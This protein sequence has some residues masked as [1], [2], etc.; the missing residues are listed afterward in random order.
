MRRIVFWIVAVLAAW[1]PPFGDARGQDVLRIAAIVN[2]EV[3]TIRDLALRID[4]V[5]ASTRFEDTPDNRSRLRNR[6]LRQLIDER[7]QLA[8]A[9]R[10]GISVAPADIDRRLVGLARENNMSREQFEDV[11]K[12]N[13][14]DIDALVQ[15]I[16]ADIAWGRVAQLRL[17]PLA[18][19]SDEE[20]DDGLAKFESARGQPEALVAE[21]LLP[22]DVR[23]HEDEALRAA[24]R[25]VDQIKA[26]AN[27]AAVARQFSGGAT[28]S[29]GGDIGWL[30]PGQ[31]SPELDNVVQALEVGQI[32]EPIRSVGGFT[33]LTVKERRQALAADPMSTTVTLS[34][35]VAT[36][37]RGAPPSAVEEARQKAMALA[38]VAVG[39]E[40]LDRRAAAA[41]APASGRLGN[42]SLRDLPADVRNMMATLPL[43]RASQPLQSDI[44]FRVLMVCE[45]TAPPEAKPPSRA[46]IQA[47]LESR[48]VALLAQRYLRNLRRDAF[49]EIR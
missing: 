18:K 21:I 13:G 19:V 2:E 20:V 43:G 12:R 41:K 36:I 30:L 32:S 37:D 46:D 38:S 49:V 44:G 9:K 40:D 3:I 7:L 47:G 23:D 39:C 24:Q 26:G 35:F 27:F 5:I 28:A 48:R 42:F 14:M 25:L 31:L 45:R 4:L 8:E 33:I 15:Q 16:T 29:S 1:L 6:V 22:V 17:R 34:Q 10:L 11:L